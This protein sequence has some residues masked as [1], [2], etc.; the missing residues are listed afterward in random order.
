MAIYPRGPGD[1]AVDPVTLQR[2]V[3]GIFAACGMSDEDA[4]LLAGSLVASDR[5]GILSH[6]VLRVPDYVKKMT[7][8]GVD[9]RGRPMIVSDRGAAIVIDGDNSMGQIGG[10]FAMEAVA[11]SSSPF[12]CCATQ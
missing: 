5:R 1:R 12:R 3:T 2:V 9:P 7:H 6:G 8:D 10:T 4:A 11:E